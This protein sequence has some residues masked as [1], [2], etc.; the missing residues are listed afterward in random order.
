MVETKILD[1][2]KIAAQVRAEIAEEIKKSGITPRLAV[3][4][5]GDHPASQIYVR[6]KKKMAQEVGIDVEEYHLPASTGQGQVLDLI[7]ALNEREEI[8]GI[9]VQLPVPPHIE[10]SVLTERISPL[11]DVDGLHPMNVGNLVVGKPAFVPCTPLGCMRLLKEAIPHPEG[12]HAV[13]VGRS[14]LVGRP[15]TTLLLRE[16]CTVTQA[17]SR[18]KNLSELCRQ[19]DILVAAVGKPGLIKGEDIKEGAVVIDVGINRLSDGKIVGDILFLE[20]MEKASYVTPV[21][22]GVGPMTIAMLLQNT[23]RA[24]QLKAGKKKGVIR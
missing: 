1:G 11:K 21:P 7:D 22:G 20:M 9:L 10:T 12:L 18:T 17:H 23:L 4:L 19:A 24:S 5:V 14:A 3:V 16:N 6:N 15:L 2:K 8:D 13:V